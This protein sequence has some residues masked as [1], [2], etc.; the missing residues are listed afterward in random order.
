[1][2]GFAGILGFGADIDQS[3]VEAMADRIRHRGPDDSGAWIDTEAGVGLTHRRLSIVD[4][5]AAGHQPMVST[6][7]RFVI[8]FNGEIYN[9]LEIRAALAKEGINWR[10]HSDTETLLAGFVRWGVEDTL[11]R[12]VGMFAIALWDR[13]D[14]LLRLVR[15]RMGEKPLYYGWQGGV[16]LFGS[17]LKALR[18]HPGFRAGVDRQALKLFMR[19][20]YIPAPFS[21]HE[22][23]RKLLPGSI[24]TLPWSQGEAR[25]RLVEPERY[26]RLEDVARAGLESPFDGSESEAVDHLESVLS[27][28]VRLQQ[29]ADV[30]L[31][32]LLSGGVDSSTIVALMQGMS[33]RRVKTFSVGF[34]E[35]EYD[36]SPYGRA[37]AHHLGTEHTELKVQAR[38]A[39]DLIPKLSQIYD[40]P[41]ADASQVPTYLVSKLARTHVTVAL[42]GD[43]GDELFCGYNRYLH[44]ASLDQF[45]D[46][47]PLGLRQVAAQSLTAL[48]ID[49]WNRINSTIQFLIPESMRVAHAGEKVHRLAAV[50]QASD[51]A[52]IHQLAVSRWSTVESLVLGAGAEPKS[53]FENSFELSLGAQVEHSMMLRDSLGYLPDDILVKVDRASMAVS[54]EARVPMLDHRVVE[55]AWRL[56]LGLKLRQGQGKWVL[57]QVLYRHVPRALIERPKKG[58]S[59]PIDQWLR[60]ALRPW[61]EAL[62][63]PALI[64]SQGFFDPEPIRR[65]WIEHQ[66]GSRN[67]QDALWNVLM[68]Q[69]WLEHN[70]ADLSDL[71]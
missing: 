35:T 18:A 24:L 32:A 51:A 26:W 67:H 10:G 12:A 50:I 30:P 48:S 4:L 47:V 7:G 21:I 27:D 5:S 17:E 28:A 52:S 55:F 38:D 20:S 56:P 66:N 69:A 64:R 59:V 46:R 39:L 19:Y 71:F 60:G 58:F 61:A 16:F 45:V 11:R 2:C 54:L 53:S 33:N 1:M 23:I 8:A 14:R 49:R 44:A 65:V 13:Q 3:I 15:D 68:F 42:S 37:V 9:H 31:G 25:C 70:Q 29:M 40:E 22:G 41:F 63:D 43:A 36:E 6:C 57:R 62:I 34:D